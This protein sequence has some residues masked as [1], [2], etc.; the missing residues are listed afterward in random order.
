MED[1]GVPTEEPE[2]SSSK[3][4]NKLINTVRLICF[5]LLGFFFLFFEISKLTMTI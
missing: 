2:L 1:Q 4:N 5:F 3:S